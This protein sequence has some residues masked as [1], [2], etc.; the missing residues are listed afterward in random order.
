MQHAGRI[1][2]GSSIGTL[3]PSLTSIMRHCVVHTW[4]TLLQDIH[5]DKLRFNGTAST[6]NLDSH[7]RPC[8]LHVRQ[9]QHAV[10]S[11]MMPTVVTG[12]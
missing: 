9:L 3:E 12:E 2:R 8:N 5:K 6:D 4:C 10:G 1:R 7:L 11:Y